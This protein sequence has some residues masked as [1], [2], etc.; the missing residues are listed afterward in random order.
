MKN[1]SICGMDKPLSAF[2]KI[3]GGRVGTRAYCKQCHKETYG[4]RQAAK[5]KTPDGH[6]KLSAW[7]R[8]RERSEAAKARERRSAANRRENY[9]AKSAA[10]QAVR[11]ALKRGDLVRPEACEKCGIVPPKGKNGRSYVHGHHDDYS[12]PLTVRWLCI[13]CHAE[14]HRALAQ[15]E[16]GAS[17]AKPDD[18]PG[19]GVLPK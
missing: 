15:K 11:N 4:A 2:H 13:D 18:V 6:K 12:K 17:A 1:C 14:Y 16:A 8:G 7:N 9:P 19:D 5:R 3:G 10:Q